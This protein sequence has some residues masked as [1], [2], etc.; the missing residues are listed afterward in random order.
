[1]KLRRLRISRLPGIDEMFEIAPEGEGF[2]I[3]FGPNGI[4]KSSICRAVEALFW[5]DRGPARQTS[6]DGQF[7]LDGEEWRA[8]REGA[9]IRWQRGGEDC[10]PPSLP[11]SYQH[12]CFFLHL[13]DLIDPSTEGTRDVAVEIRRQMSGGFDLGGVVS[14]L[15]G[16]VGARHG[17]SERRNYN[18]ALQQIQQTVGEHIGLQRRADQIKD[19]EAQLEQAQRSE[20]RIAFVE[21]AKGLAERRENLSALV[22]ELSV[23]PKSL[24][25]LTGKESEQIGTLQ[26]GVAKLNDRIGSLETQVATA[27]K[28]QRDSGLE[29]PL[30]AAELAAWRERANSLSRM[31]IAL[32][33]ARTEYSGCRAERDAAHSAIGGSSGDEVNFDL[34]DHGQLYD[35]LRAVESH[36]AKVNAIRERLNLLA[37]IGHPE[38]GQRV[39]ERT[40]AAAE[41]LRVWLRAP[42][43]EMASGASGARRFWTFAAIALGAVGTGLAVIADPAFA[44]L[45]AIGAGIGLPLLFQRR[46]RVVSDERQIARDTFGKLGVEPPKTWD[47][48][49]VESRLR[50]LESDAAKMDAAEQRAR[51]RDV[52]RQS[53]QNAQDELSDAQTGL[54]AKRQRLQES[55]KLEGLPPDAELVDLARA[56][57]QLRLARSKERSAAGKVVGLEARQSELLSNL[58]EALERYGE[59]RPKDAAMAQASL[60]Q[61]ASR[62]TKLQKAVSD[63]QAAADKLSE[64]SADRDTAVEAIAQVYSDA[65][66]DEGDSHGLAALLR[67]LPGYMEQTGERTRLDGKVELDRTELEKAGEGDL[68]QLDKVAL[69]E[70][71]EEL[72]RAAASATERRNEI[73]EIKADVKAAR[74]G[75]SIQDLIAARDELLGKLQDRQH[76]ALFAKAGRLLM[77]SVEQEHEQTQMPRVLERA[78]N[79]FSA[80]THHNYDIR[81][82]SDAETPRLI[83]VDQKT[84]EGKGL[85]KLSDGTRAQLLLAARMAFSEEVDQGR[86]LPLFLDEALGQSDPVRYEAIVR[87]LGRVAKDQDRQIFYFTSDPADVNRIQHALAEEHCDA[88]AEIDLGLV[89]RNAASVSGPGAL[90]VEPRPPIPAPDGLTA[91]EY[92]AALGV[93]S[94]DPALGYAHQHFFHVLWDDLDLLHG[95]LSNGIVRA[96]QWRTV[97]ESALAAK[98]CARS[99]SSGEI[100]IRLNL[101]ENFCEYWN[102]GRGRLVDREVLEDS[103]ALT[104]RFIDNV[105]LIAAELG[106]DSEKL[107]DTLRSREDSRL[108]GF[109]TNSLENLERYLR[110]NG[111]VDEHPV[112][113]EEELRLLALASPAAPQLPEGF[114]DECI[115]RWWTLAARANESET[116]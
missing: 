33:A 36:K 99:I 72:L 23:L 83:A 90:H 49:S 87:S 77:D 47:V 66:L 94:L 105:A 86:T 43:P 8:E 89:R 29:A 14:D 41:A 26:S 20:R 45:A 101:L 84:G 110:E 9:R 88:A 38:D 4:G 93:P 16:G 22:E 11:P 59:K 10:A 73:A 25:K 63:E 48:S 64:A 96:G 113:N 40:R 56:L 24:A 17:R 80:F 71:N 54:D 21:R 103:G 15:F 62:D 65:G 116:E 3:V 13:R 98:L 111:Y 102:K 107:L 75:H 95:F 46:R 42:G 70:L 35:F 97:S 58:A 28:D 44:L 76:E 114:A 18:E 82:S 19:L 104:D 32:E 68:V 81:M 52:E 51:V 115:N 37:S 39:F 100:S 61:L 30:E 6:I 79:L 7:E 85:D 92:G 57:D 67:L 69:E 74:R 2:H 34:A 112:L 91:D 5:S 108:K 12:N 78:R 1:M 50:D 27:R 60:N 31:E 109:R 106:G 55:L 53:F